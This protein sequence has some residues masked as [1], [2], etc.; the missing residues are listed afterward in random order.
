MPIDPTLAAG[1]LQVLNAGLTSINNSAQNR[2][3]RRMYMMQRQDALSDYHMQNQYNHP[4]SQMARLREA[5][6]NPNLVYGN[7]NSIT[8]SAK[9]DNATLKSSQRQPLQFNPQDTLATINNLKIQQAQADNL[10]V[11]N[12]VLEQERILKEAQAAETAV[13]T[14]N[15]AQ[16]TKTSE[17]DLGL[18]SEM[19]KLSI[20]AAIANLNKTQADTRYTLD[21]NE[22]AAVSNTQS[23]KESVQ[24]IVNMKVGNQL[25]ETQMREIEQR[26]KVLKIDERIKES[27]AKM[28]EKGINPNDPT[29]MRIIAQYADEIINSASTYKGL[30]KT[31]KQSL[32]KAMPWPFSQF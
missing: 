18:K 13:R 21:N 16:N 4:S 6:L 7:G 8:P 23:I 9:V 32:M 10:R 12:S 28:R 5:G 19:R 30:D 27:E 31:S 1:G 3:D 14:V 17:F 2:Q 20:D 29:W 25:S 15:I 26:I 22:R 24:R 11:Q